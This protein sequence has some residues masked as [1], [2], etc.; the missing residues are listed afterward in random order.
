[1]CIVDRHCVSNFRIKLIRK[2]ISEFKKKIKIW[3]LNQYS[4]NKFTIDSVIIPINFF[5]I[6]P[7][8]NSC[9][10]PRLA[11]V[12]LLC[13]TRASSSKRRWIGGHVVI[14]HGESLDVTMKGRDFLN[15][16]QKKKKGKILGYTLLFLRKKLMFGVLTSW[17]V[18]EKIIA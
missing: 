2:I 9:T 13:A 14:S 1:M 15:K 11:Y 10:G 8:S 5:L 17:Q 18:K 4:Y 3:G 6:S 16:Y 7:L 12:C